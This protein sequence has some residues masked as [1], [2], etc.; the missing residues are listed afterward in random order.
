MTPTINMVGVKYA[1]ITVSFPTDIHVSP[2]IYIFQVLAENDI[3]YST[4]RNILDFPQHVFPQKELRDA[5]V[6]V[7]KL[8]SDFDV[9]MRYL[10]GVLF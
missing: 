4:E 6:T 1:S 5:S 7:D 9:E 2:F 3:K 8:L 10:D